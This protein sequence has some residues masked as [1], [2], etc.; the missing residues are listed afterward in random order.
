MALQQQQRL[1]SQILQ[2][3]ERHNRD[4]AALQEELQEQRKQD[5]QY[6]RNPEALKCLS[7]NA[8]KQLAS[9]S[10]GADAG[11]ALYYTCQKN[12]K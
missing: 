5:E 8:L 11:T 3:E 4:I 12:M 6:S 2:Q 7:D 10:L 9:L 1:T